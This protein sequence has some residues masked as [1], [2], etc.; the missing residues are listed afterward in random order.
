[1]RQ[2]LTADG[3]NLV[4]YESLEEERGATGKVRYKD[5]G[6]A[7]LVRQT[8]E[9]ELAVSFAEPRRA[10]TPGQS[11]VLYEGEDV[12]GGGWIRKVEELAVGVANS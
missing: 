5:P 4:K 3:V 11:V 12:L 2:T 7:C 6:A 1:M 10:I 8:A 9:S